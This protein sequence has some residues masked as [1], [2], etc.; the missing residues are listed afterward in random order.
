MAVTR[1]D[2][3]R[4]TGLDL[5]E[6]S[7]ENFTVY[8][9]VAE[10]QLAADLSGRILREP[11]RTRALSYLIASYITP[12]E[13]KFLLQ[14]EKIGD[15]SWTGKTSEGLTTWDD[16]YQSLLPTTVV[17][18]SRNAGKGV[19]RNDTCLLDLGGPTMTKC[20]GRR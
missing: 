12:T 20:W 15:F 19:K 8:A 2:V 18:T 14:S 7:D 13:E 5:S 6:V 1:A 9:L 17:G 16:L 10:Q 4:W 3:E 11:T